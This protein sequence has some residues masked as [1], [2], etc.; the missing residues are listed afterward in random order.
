MF[1]RFRKYRLSPEIRDNH[2]DVALNARDFILPYFVVDGDA[3]KEP[4]P[5][6]KGVYRLSVDLLLQDVEETIN[7]G[8]DKILLFGVPDTKDRTKEAVNA[9][10]HNNLI[11]RTVRLLKEKFPGLTVITDVCTCAYNNHGHCGVLNGLTVDNDKTLEVLAKIA[12][13]HARGG[14]D[15]VAPSAMMDGQVQS[16]R[17]KLDARGYKQ[18]KILSNSAKYASGLYSPFS[19]VTL[20]KPS[21]G[22][23]KV[24][25][26]DFRTKLQGIEEI[27]ADIE[28]G[29]D[30]VM[31]QPANTYLDVIARARDKY[32]KAH[33]VG[34]QSS[35][36]YMMIQN[37]A[38]HGYVE[39]MPAMVESLTSIK[40]AGANYIVSYFAKKM[41]YHIN[42]DPFYVI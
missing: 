6:L 23:R 24:Y 42:G 33:I 7:M 9:F 28:E 30:L 39:L 36:E 17:K 10:K 27:G 13:S 37:G 1:Q 3:R 11:E 12:E 19:D 26:I 16:I 5:S 29:A 18:T 38:E 20:N 8:I 21:F 40:R 41:A 4:V 31:V 14:A 2:A 22:D 15:I 34:F 32:E 35:G 25:Q